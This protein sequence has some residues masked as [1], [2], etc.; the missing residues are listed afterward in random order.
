MLTHSSAPLPLLTMVTT[1]EVKD[2][3][4]FFYDY[5]LEAEPGYALPAWYTPV[6]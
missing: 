4:E 3:Q 5:K 1:D 2:G 6:A